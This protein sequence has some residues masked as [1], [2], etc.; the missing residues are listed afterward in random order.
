MCLL[1]PHRMLSNDLHWDPRV[2]VEWTANEIRWYVDGA[3][4]HTAEPD[5]VSGPWVFNKPFYLILNVAVGGGFVGAPDA[6]TT[7]PQTMLVDWVRVY[8]QQQ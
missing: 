7:F 6:S 5:F 3:L 1:G 4:Y 8:E 2:T